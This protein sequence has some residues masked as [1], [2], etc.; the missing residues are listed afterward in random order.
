MEIK[1][2]RKERVF[3]TGGSGFLGR[4]IIERL[5]A[6]GFQ[7]VALARRS[8]LPRHLQHP[9][10]E[11]VL[12]DMRDA[13]DL[14]QHLARVDY[15][16]HAA[17]TMR[18]TWED[19]YNTNVQGTRTLL[20][21]VANKPIK[22]FIYISSASVYRHANLKKNAFFT[23]DMP[24]EASENATFY[25]RSKIEAEHLVRK[26]QCDADLPTVIL[27]PGAIYGPGG[28]VFP[29]TIGLGIGNGKVITIGDART[30]LPLSYVENVADV[31]V[32][33]FH[34][35]QA[36]GEIFNL[37]EEQTLSRRQYLRRLK[38]D[39]NPKVRVLAFPLWF[40]QLMRLSLKIA[41]SFIDKTAPLSALNLKLYCTSVTYSNQ[42]ATEIFGDKPFVGF[43]ESLTRTMQWQRE[44]FTPKRSHALENTA[45]I[46]PTAQKLKVGLI[47]CG[48]IANVHMTFLRKF[49]NAGEIVV[50][51]P[52]EKT[53]QAFKRQ[54][55]IEKTYVDYKKMLDQ[56][57]PAVVHILTPPQFHAEVTLSAANYGAHVLVEKPMAVDTVQA[58]SMVAA[59]K[60]HN[61][62]LCV[63][64]N[65]LY[66]RVMIQA[67]EILAQQLLGR[68]TYVES[69]YGTQFGSQ[70]PAF[71]PETYWAYTLPGSLYQDYLPH[72][73]YNFLEV[74]GE[75]KIRDVVAKYAGGVPEVE[76]DELKLLFE[77]ADRFG[78]VSMSLSVSPRFQFMLVYGTEGSMKIDFLN[79][80]ILLDKEIGGLPKTINR[81]RRA[82][83]HARTLAVASFQ[84][85]LRMHRVNQNLFEGTD[86]IIRLFYRSILMDE[87]EP[88]SGEEA[89]QLMHFL[90][91]VWTRLSPPVEDFAKKRRA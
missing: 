64:H 53:L 7:V 45:V 41:F 62:K 73:L 9:R 12:G 10:I 15:V 39:V 6:D 80:C 66:D 43:E 61:V 22:R 18:G 20:E 36:I 40:M 5:L 30:T 71:D 70:E 84:N 13:A 54:H 25:A 67:R 50:A 82:F 27:R 68:V 87:P 63:V 21:A 57:R 86:R 3:V 42:K 47:G 29:A 24:Y 2:K 56:E 46:L 85:T 65:H 33:S 34:N 49:A 23:E 38:S 79:K 89:L 75:A 31:I 88:V 11:L 26:Y 37:T 17:A 51:D 32:R 59:A 69:W 16:V 76:T 8:N 81:A 44:R 58:K 83:K 77:S 78:M 74:M 19:F 14:F 48:N 35:Q 1:R 60:R 72:A 4:A 52:Q 90:D 28:Y 91:E 55:Q